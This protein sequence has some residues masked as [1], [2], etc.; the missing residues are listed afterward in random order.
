MNATEILTA[1]DAARVDHHPGR[2][3]VRDLPANVLPATGHLAIDPAGQ[4]ALLFHVPDAGETLTD[5]T[6]DGVSLARL[7]LN[8]GGSIVQHVALILRRDDLVRP[9]A[10]LVADVLERARSGGRPDQVC[11]EALERW[12]ELLTAVGRPLSPA[13]QVGIFGELWQLRELV[14]V[15][16]P[17]VSRWWVGPTG[18]THDFTGPN[19]V[20]LEV[21]TSRGKQARIVTISGLTQLEC[22]P[23]RSLF[24]SVLRIDAGAGGETLRDLVEELVRL[25][26]SG[27]GLREMLQ[28]AGVDD[29]SL[30]DA[31]VRFTVTEQRV[32]AVDA[33]F[34]RLE[35]PQ[36]PAA[37]VHPLIVRVSYDIDL[38]AEPP[39]PMSADAVGEV[40]ARFVG[41]TE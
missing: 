9:F 2:V 27:V 7:E 35:R 25:G 6:S 38:T 14:R 40:Y 33:A 37:P 1:I 10:A 11:V 39:V 29:R 15:A 17:A 31:S 41:E 23:P 28:F 13:R 32:Y 30:A 24:L 16:G 26:C 36:P 12:R 18:A 3:A 4:A 21:K 5:T 20:D 34:P 8:E 19:G 22:E